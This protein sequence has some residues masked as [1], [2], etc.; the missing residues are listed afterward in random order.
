MQRSSK[1]DRRSAV[2]AS[3]VAFLILS[4]LGFTQGPPAPR[5]LTWGADS[6]G[7]APYE[8]PD[9]QDPSKIIGFEVDIVEAIGRILG[10]PAQF[11]QNQWDGLI[12]GLERGNYDIVVSGLEITPDRAQVINF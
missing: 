6:E 3:V 9:P 1:A 4:P 11:V 7:G 8:F 2:V 5:L 12:P 10:R